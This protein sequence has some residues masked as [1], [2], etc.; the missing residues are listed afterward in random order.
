MNAQ[1]QLFGS[2]R[3]VKA[4][5]RRVTSGVSVGA[6]LGN[7]GIPGAPGESAPAGWENET[8]S[9]NPRTNG[10]PPRGLPVRYCT[11]PEERLLDR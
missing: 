8:Q 1:R 9:G 3:S 2:N 11:A 7:I 6:S 10:E 5:G 4:G